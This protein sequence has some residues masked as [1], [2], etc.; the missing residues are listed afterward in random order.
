MTYYPFAKQNCH[1]TL[2]LK[3]SDRTFLELNWTSFIDLVQDVGNYEILS[4]KILDQV[5]LKLA[6]IFD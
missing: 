2:S 3:K 5:L 6:I 4:M 1:S